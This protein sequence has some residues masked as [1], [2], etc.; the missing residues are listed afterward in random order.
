MPRLVSSNAERYG[1]IGVTFALLAWLIVI[2]FTVVAAAVVSAE[3]GG[4]RRPDLAAADG[5]P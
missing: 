4:A 5:E 3:I 1:V 2:G